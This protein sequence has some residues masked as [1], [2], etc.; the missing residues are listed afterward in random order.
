M[1]KNILTLCTLVLTCIT[2]QAQDPYTVV[3]YSPKTNTLTTMHY[4]RGNTLETITVSGETQTTIRVSPNGQPKQI[5]NEFATL[6]YQFAGTSKVTV[7]QTVNGETQVQSVPMNSD[8]VLKFR[9]AFAT[10]KKNFFDAVDKA[11]KFLEN[12]GAKL[13]GGLVGAINDGLKNPIGMCFGQAL[14]AAQKTDNPIIPINSLQ[15]LALA[16]REYEGVK[17]EIQ[18]AAVDF[19]FN[20]YKE[21]RDGW[22]DFI[23]NL[24]VE[25]DRKQQAEN[26]KKNEW[27]LNLAKLLLGAGHSPEEITNALNNAKNPAGTD[28]KPQPSGNGSQPSGNAPQPNANKPQP[29]SDTS[30]PSTEAAKPSTEAS[31]PEDNKMPGNDDSTLTEVDISNMLA[32]KTPQDIINFANLLAKNNNGKKPLGFN[33]TY[34]KYFM[35]GGGGFD[36]W[37]KKD[38][39]GY[40][41]TAV[42]EGVYIDYDKV[43][44]KPYCRIVVWWD[45][46]NKTYDTYEIPMKAEDIADKFS[47]K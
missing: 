17:D 14:D 8:Y 22:S 2:S 43:L 45:R 24:Q 37:I 34:Y 47:L 38:K 39:S 4:G 46:L 7:T 36:M 1:K 3:G 32:P 29:N 11:D 30:K 28:A 5:S 27:R 10:T 15:A 23:Y 19:I 16:T 33:V 12:G 26:K 6:D 44:E 21:W 41:V 9:A 20:N 35:G 18:G 40:E 31:K 25:K 13:V 42:Y